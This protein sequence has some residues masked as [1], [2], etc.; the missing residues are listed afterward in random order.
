MTFFTAMQYLENL[1]MSVGGHMTLAMVL[2]ES[3]AILMPVALSVMLRA[4]RTEPGSIS[5]GFSIGHI[6]HESFTDGAH[7]LVLG[8]T[9]I[10]FISGE[11]GKS[12]SRFTRPWH[13]V[14]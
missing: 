4:R 5:P 12:A 10:D 2:M 3:P 14:C 9:A 11:A 7:L 1:G 8:A 13:R 6:L